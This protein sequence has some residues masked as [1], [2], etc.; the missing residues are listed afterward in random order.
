MDTIVCPGHSFHPTPPFSLSMTSSSLPS[1]LSSLLH[2]W[3]GINHDLMSCARE[4]FAL[5]PRQLDRIEA[6][7]ET[8]QSSK[9]SLSCATGAMTPARRSTRY[10]DAMNEYDG[11]ADD[12]DEDDDTHVLGIPPSALMPTLTRHILSIY[13][14]VYRIASDSFDTVSRRRT[15][16]TAKRVSDRAG[17]DVCGATVMELFVHLWTVAFRA[18]L[19]LI[20]ETDS[21]RVDLP[22]SAFSSTHAPFTTAGGHDEGMPSFN[23]TWSVHDD[24]SNKNNTNSNCNKDHMIN[25]ASSRA[26]D[27]D[28]D[29]RPLRARAD[30]PP[31]RVPDGCAR[32][33][34]FYPWTFASSSFYSSAE[35]SASSRVCASL[36][37]CRPMWSSSSSSSQH[38]RSRRMPCA[39]SGVVR[40]AGEGEKDS[41]SYMGAV[42]ALLREDDTGLIG[43][44]ATSEEESIWLHALRRTRWLWQYAVLDSV[45][46]KRT[47]A[48]RCAC[49]DEHGRCRH[50]VAH[51]DQRCSAGDIHTTS[52]ATSDHGHCHGSSGC[53]DALPVSS[54]AV[55]SRQCVRDE[56]THMSCSQDRSVACAC[57]P[58]SSSCAIQRHAS[59]SIHKCENGASCSCTCSCC[60]CC[61][62]GDCVCCV[63]SSLTSPSSAGTPISLVRAHDER[64][65]LHTLSSLALHYQ[66]MHYIARYA[67]RPL[68][69]AHVVH[70]RDILVCIVREVLHSNRRA[71]LRVLKLAAAVM[72]APPSEDDDTPEEPDEG[73]EEEEIAVVQEE[74]L[75]L[76]SNR[77]A[78]AGSDLHPS[79]TMQKDESS[80]SAHH[81]ISVDPQT[82]VIPFWRQR[83]DVA[84]N[85]PDARG[86]ANGTPS[87]PAATRTRTQRVALQGAYGTT[88]RQSRHGAGLCMRAISQE[89]RWV[90]EV[91]LPMLHRIRVM[92]HS[93]GLRELQ[94]SVVESVMQ[95]CRERGQQ[96]GRATLG[97]LCSITTALP[98]ARPVSV[99]TPVN[100]GMT[101]SSETTS[102]AAHSTEDTTAAGMCNVH[103]INDKADTIQHLCQDD[104]NENKNDNTN[105]TNNDSNSSHAV[106]CE[107]GRAS[108]SVEQAALP[109]SNQDR[110]SAAAAKATATA[111]V[112]LTSSSLIAAHAALRDVVQNYARMRAALMLFNAGNRHYMS[113]M[114]VCAR[115]DLAREL[116]AF[117]LGIGMHDMLADFV[118]LWGVP[119]WLQLCTYTCCHMS[120]TNTQKMTPSQPLPRL[121]HNR[122]T[123]PLHTSA[124][125][126]ASSSS[127]P[128]TTTA[129][130]TTH[131]ASSSSSSWRLVLHRL[132]PVSI[133]HALRDCGVR[134]PGGMQ[135]ECSDSPL[136]MHPS[137]AAKRTRNTRPSIP[138]T[139]TASGSR[140]RGAAINCSAPC[141]SRRQRAATHITD[142][143]TTRS[144]VCGGGGGSSRRLESASEA[145]E[146]GLHRRIGMNQQPAAAAVYHMCASVRTETHS[147]RRRRGRR[148]RWWWQLQMQQRQR[149]R[150]QRQGQRQGVYRPPRCPRW[151]WMQTTAT[152]HAGESVRRARQRGTSTRSWRS[153]A[154]G[155]S[156]HSRYARR[157]DGAGRDG[158]VTATAAASAADMYDA[159]GSEWEAMSSASEVSSAMDR[160]HSH[161]VSSLSHNGFTALL[162]LVPGKPTRVREAIFE[163]LSQG[164]RAHLDSL[165]QSYLRQDNDDDDE[166]ENVVD[167]GHA[168]LQTQQQKRPKPMRRPHSPARRMIESCL[169]ARR[170]TRATFAGELALVAALRRA[171]FRETNVASRDTRTM[172]SNPPNRG[173]PHNSDTNNSH[174]D[175]NNNTN[176]SA[177]RSTDHEDS[178]T[179]Q[180]TP[181][182]SHDSSSV[183]PSSEN[184]H[185]DAD[186]EDNLMSMMARIMG[187]AYDMQA[188]DDNDDDDDDRDVD[189]HNDNAA[190]SHTR[191]AASS[192]L[193]G[194]GYRT[195]V[196]H[197]VAAVERGVGRFVHAHDEELIPALAVL[198]Q[199]RVREHLF[200]P[201]SRTI[202]PQPVGGLSS[203]SASPE[204]VSPSATSATAAAAAAATWTEQGEKEESDEWVVFSTL[205]SLPSSA[206]PTPQ[207]PSSTT[208]GGV[209]VSSS[210]LRPGVCE[211]AALAHTPP[212]TRTSR[213]A[214]ALVSVPARTSALPVDPEADGVLAMLLEFAAQLPSPERLMTH[215]RRLL[216]LDW[217]SLPLLLYPGLTSYEAASSSYA[218]VYTTTTRPGVTAARSVSAVMA[219]LKTMARVLQCFAPHLGPAAM[220][221]CV[222]MLRDLRASVYDTR[223]RLPRP[224]THAAA[225]PVTRGS[226][227]SSALS[228][229]YRD[230]CGLYRHAPHVAQSYPRVLG[231]LRVLC[232][233]WWSVS[234]DAEDRAA[235]GVTRVQEMEAM[236]CTCATCTPPSSGLVPSREVQ[237]G[238]ASGRSPAHVPAS[239]SSLVQ[240]RR[241]KWWSE[242][243]LDAM[244]WVEW[245]YTK[246]P[247]RH[248]PLWCREDKNS[249]HKDGD[250]NEENEGCARRAGR[251]CCLGTR[252]EMMRP[253]ICPVPTHEHTHHHHHQPCRHSLHGLLSSHRHG[254]HD[255]CDVCLGPGSH[256]HACSGGTVA[257]TDTPCNRKGRH[258]HGNEQPI[259]TMSNTTATPLH[260]E[261]TPHEPSRRGEPR[262][263][264]RVSLSALSASTSSVMQSV[265]S[266]LSQA[267]Q[268][269]SHRWVDHWRTTERLSGQFGNDDYESDN[270]EEQEAEEEEESGDGATRG[271]AQSRPTRNGRTSRSPPPS[272]TSSS[273]PFPS[274]SASALLDTGETH[275]TEAPPI[276]VPLTQATRTFFS[277]AAA[278]LVSS[279]RSSTP[280]LRPTAAP[281]TPSAAWGAVTRS[282]AS[283]SSSS[284]VNSGRVAAAAAA[285]V[286]R[287]STPPTTQQIVAD[288]RERRQLCWPLC[289]G[290]LTFVVHA[291]HEQKGVLHNEAEVASETTAAGAKLRTC[292]GTLNR[293]EK[294]PTKSVHVMKVTGPPVTLLVLQC[295]DAHGASCNVAAA[296]SRAD[297]LPCTLFF[298]H[299]QLPIRLPLRV[300]ASVL[301]ALLDGGVIARR[302]NHRLRQHEYYVPDEFARSAAVTVSMRRALLPVST[303][304]V[305]KRSYAVSPPRGKDTSHTREDA[306]TRA[307]PCMTTTTTN[308]THTCEGEV[309]VTR[310]MTV[311][312]HVVPQEACGMQSKDSLCADREAEGQK[313]G[314]CGSAAVCGIASS[315]QE[316]RVGG[317]EEDAAADWRRVRRSVETTVVRVMKQN[318]VMTHE[319][320]GHAVMSALAQLSVTPA[321]LKASVEQLIHRGFM[322]REATGEYRYLV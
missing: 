216:A 306:E 158:L 231:S 46:G 289:L 253:C 153:Q 192:S 94:K 209:T 257:A 108:Q 318:T 203:S 59:S 261:H 113:G 20:C 57:A 206:A 277:A 264:L 296:R 42:H 86:E 184:D 17:T 187:T 298:I 311:P 4:V 55:E 295:I 37:S 159:C 5:C 250:E 123:L 255:G 166:N 193:L 237:E 219:M 103:T 226:S 29:H 15:T 182:P 146:S 107:L 79:H 95:C 7:D 105:N 297:V 80:L 312:T 26:D 200:R 31:R 256:E 99:A 39:P 258:V 262:R 271:V 44:A 165:W 223:S 115:A 288:A 69:S 313:P 178:H 272:L 169:V 8:I 242:V 71:L 235:L 148:R 171:R 156:A 100:T 13:T 210:R 291:R 50:C 236:M 249:V 150:R 290:S 23:P 75:T 65:R 305:V 83:E 320:L 232:L 154:G 310:T 21:G 197:A 35:C 51:E 53:M 177:D 64:R 85:S 225:L 89:V 204:D 238:C 282:T 205:A 111:A 126:N 141:R 234:H 199:A 82:P 43:G 180:P 98:P 268:Q 186:E 30:P 274:A 163:R 54:C 285:A 6:D 157:S 303:A 224:M 151:G 119:L 48:R 25:D 125:C 217:M 133:R 9:V 121:P 56:E 114:T 120:E 45:R 279:T 322:E 233:A 179:N 190:V 315:L 129:T 280:A 81:R 212:H 251:V 144:R 284:L 263:D 147:L 149:R 230:G 101:A 170:L 27:A 185:S 68:E 122:D 140:L 316:K 134:L 128:L 124:L 135:P 317:E 18:W 294:A 168:P 254:P 67:F 201:P 72:I 138:A 70:P 319:A 49:N 195:A 47:S 276:V 188:S 293:R 77:A 244:Q 228:A 176:A 220:D 304:S 270:E 175:D 92:L 52:H 189:D 286:P 191:A 78:P 87:L 229:V 183:S 160:L 218:S 267:V 110:Q 309:M 207:S 11:D 131:A 281:R 41:T 84:H 60:C 118:T 88:M 252:C 275:R 167:D 215:V 260:V 3:E 40:G 106:E 287:T 132:V 137:C 273:P 24:H 2:E 139:E 74:R 34:R 308:N 96:V 208:D 265:S 266:V 196:E 63:S 127:R 14:R 58:N 62:C 321:M 240:G 222:A 76:E 173:T 91:D 10:K 246:H 194:R 66:I 248:V 292:S 38:D 102:R 198:L 172:S 32:R 112:V 28:A 302:P 36:S 19:R 136:S 214:S 90:Y 155:H 174:Y 202:Q 93:C 145:A 278:A 299:E 117:L 104:T 109:L 73:E 61:C 16:G 247:A 307:S 314:E 181:R 239:L 162:C 152:S 164:V 221:V 130:T 243:L 22:A 245:Y 300:L 213:S 301:R 1:P 116:R 259:A 97:H 161:E 241:V 211:A 12:E 227:A 33:Y 269:R 143:T 283:I 142:D